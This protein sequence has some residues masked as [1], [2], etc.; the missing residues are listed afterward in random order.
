MRLADI[1]ED[2]I[3]AVLTQLENEKILEQCGIYYDWRPTSHFFNLPRST[4]NVREQH[5]PPV[6][7]PSPAQKAARERRARAQLQKQAERAAREQAKIEKRAEERRLRDAAVAD[8][9][10]KKQE[11]ANHLAIDE[12]NLRTT[13]ATAT[14]RVTIPMLVPKPNKPKSPQSGDPWDVLRARAL[15]R[16]AP[17]TGP[18]IVRQMTPEERRAGRPA[19]RRNLSPDQ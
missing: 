3:E 7:Y 17:A 1:P 9:D 8:R 11:Y 5:L 4:H 14:P 13:L 2:L 12:Q 19:R 18:S 6:E 15:A 16:P 10:R